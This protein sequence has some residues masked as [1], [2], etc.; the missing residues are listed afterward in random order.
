MEKQ[1]TIASEVSFSGIGLHTGNLTTI[2]FKP[3]APDTGI[4]YRRVDLPNQP[5]VPADLDHVLDTSYGTTIGTKEVQVHTIEH[6]MAAIAALGIDNLEIDIDANETP[7]GDGS[8]LPFMETL[9]KAG[10]V[11]QDADRRYIDLDQSLYYKE[12]DVTLSVLPSDEFR[13][14]MTIAFDHVAIGT[15][16]ASYS[17]TPETFE[18]E[19]APARTFGFLSEA[20]QLRDAGLI[21]GVSLENAIAFDDA[22]ILNENLRFPDE[23]VRHKILDL[24]GDMYLLGRPLRGHVIAVKSGHATHVKLSQEIAKA[25]KN[26]SKNG[27]TKKTAPPAVAAPALTTA[28]IMEALPH[29]YPFLLVDR[30]LTLTPYERVT[31]IKNV[32]ANEPF[33]Q[34]H[35]PDLP[36]MPGVIIMECMAQVS[37]MLIYNEEDL[38]KKRAYFMGID[39]GRF[40]R[41]VVPGDQLVIEAELLQMRRDA[42]KVSAKATVDGQVAA[43]G[44]MMFGL[45]ET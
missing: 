16:Y 8:A 17:I 12:D 35:W 42:F 19:I 24:V 20:K 26:G 27:A 40:R 22:S 43:Q 7:V 4:R 6:V 39:K 10:L 1:K 2:T 21:K 9:R 31:G 33:F 34:G 44:I 14:T 30:I 5:S 11:T 41:T 25:L 28:K 32:T 37:A 3:A 45:R 18:T 38:I 36:V 13:V 23:C 15:Q 29:R